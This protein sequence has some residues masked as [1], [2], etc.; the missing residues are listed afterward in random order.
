MQSSVAPNHAGLQDSA[1]QDLWAP[2][3]QPTTI[4]VTL[5]K[6]LDAI[7]AQHCQSRASDN[8]DRPF[9]ARLEAA[10]LFATAWAFEP[11]LH[12]KS[13]PFFNIL[14]RQVRAPVVLV[15]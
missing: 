10:M 15:A 11:S 6:L 9:Q 3:H 1:D 8:G 2:R 12:S 14:L 5:L 7:L 4:M 13:R